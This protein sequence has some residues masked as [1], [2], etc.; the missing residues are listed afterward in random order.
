LTAKNLTPTALKTVSVTKALFQPQ[1][2]KVG[3]RAIRGNKW[4]VLLT[5]LDWRAAHSFE[6]AM[7]RVL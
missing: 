5:R 7:K 2:I 4:R 3:E 6:V 1:P